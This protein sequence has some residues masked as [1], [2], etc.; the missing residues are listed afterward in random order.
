MQPNVPIRRR[1]TRRRLI[2]LA[3]VILSALFGPLGAGTAH[4]D[5][6]H[7][8]ITITHTPPPEVAAGDNVPLSVTFRYNCG[9][10][11]DCSNAKQRLVYSLPDGT[12]KSIE[13]VVANPEATNI[14]VWN[15]TLPGDSV[16]F[17]YVKYH[18]EV[19]VDAFE[20]WGEYTHVVSDRAPATGEYSVMAVPVVRLK[21]VRPTGLPAANLPVEITGSSVD[22]YWRAT[23]DSAGRLSFPVPTTHPWIQQVI[24]S[25]ERQAGLRVVAWDVARP[26]TNPAAGSPV[27]V[28][29]FGAVVAYQLNLGR[30][31]LPA[32]DRLS[33]DQ[34]FTLVPM[35]KT[36]YH[37]ADLS[38]S[39]S[40][41][42]SSAASGTCQDHYVGRD[43]YRR[44]LYR[45][46]LN[47]ELVRVASNLGGG[48]DTAG[49]YTYTNNIR[50]VS[51]RTF[52]ASFGKWVESKGKTTAEKTTEAK[53]ETP[54]LGPH[55]QR[56]IRVPIVHI[57]DE[58]RT[59]YY[60]DGRSQPDFCNNFRDVHQYQWGGGINYASPPS[61]IGF[62]LACDPQKDTHCSDWTEPMGFNWDGKNST[63]TGNEYEVSVSVG[64][65]ENVGL[66]AQT[67][68][69]HHAQSTT[70]VD[71]KIVEQ[72]Y[73][74]H[75]VY[76]RNGAREGETP[77]NTPQ[78]TYTAA[79][80]TDLTNYIPRDH[81]CPP[82]CPA[83]M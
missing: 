71:F 39:T 81:N 67:A 75:F 22:A 56:D 38:S 26:A 33:Q 11:T 49:M 14:D 43:R 52:S 1:W 70:E 37:E 42:A 28:E 54:W 18:F 68:H 5:D 30:I 29:G 69:T 53:A 50:T 44:C 36:Y 51:T 9:I 6:P 3:V 10:W 74:Y 62:D 80:D 31:E 63:G 40:T 57:M 82:V 83:P 59:C 47:A 19:Q 73:K 35:G 46:N 13:R 66:K 2:G 23:T 48:R 58:E 7:D 78:S 55:D 79:S 25:G 21:F 64:P 72:R 12:T 76:V 8:Y 60:S 41:T 34:A 4:A 20:A 32:S 15:V 77:A 61:F 45:W 24:T 65:Y 17:P 27:T 16:R